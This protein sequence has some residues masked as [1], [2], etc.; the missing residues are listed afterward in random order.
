MTDC[1]FCRI[2]RKEVPCQAV[3]E[4]EAVLAFCDI[5]PQAPVH[6]LV[7]PKK[8]VARLADLTSED[9]ALL[10]R[11]Q[12]SVRRLADHFSVNESGFR[13]V[14]NSGPDAG[15]AVNHLHFHFLAGRRF[16]W[17]PG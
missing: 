10:A 2:V 3:F 6:V 17:P 7:I 9:T 16:S 4:D 8:H 11:V 12:D 14:V 15:Q 5:Q 13:W 1:L